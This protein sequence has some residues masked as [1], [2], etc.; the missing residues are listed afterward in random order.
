MAR[1]PKLAEF[2]Q[3]LEYYDGPQSVLLRKSSDVWVV[4]VAIDHESSDN[5]FLGVNVSR[6]QWERYLRG[7]IDFRSLFTMPH[8]KEYYEFDLITDGHIG[9]AIKLTPAKREDHLNR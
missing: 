2:V 4:A 3:V 1:E 8:G 6:D 5:R 7:Y 9:S